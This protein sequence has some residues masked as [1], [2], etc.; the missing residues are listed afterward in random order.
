MTGR[1]MADLLR[2]K[3]LMRVPITLYRWG[4]GSLL[5]TRFVLIE[6]VGR[7]SGQ[8]R[9]VVVEVIERGPDTLYVASGWGTRSQW[10]RNLKANGI[11]RLSTGRARHVPAQVTLLSADDGD[12]VLAR[13]AQQHPRAWK[14]LS[15]AM[16]RLGTTRIPVICFTPPR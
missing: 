13:Y 1:A 9:E 11:A 7:V 10:Y 6:H 14:T 8:R 3:W 15:A 4:L 5:G 2:A 16:E 12:A